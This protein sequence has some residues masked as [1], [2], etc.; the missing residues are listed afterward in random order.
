M[1][2]TRGRW[3]SG[4][5]SS[6]VNAEY[7]ERYAAAVKGFIVFVRGYGDRIDSADDL[8]YWLAY[9]A[10]HAYTT[11]KPAK[12]TLQKALAGVEHWFPEGQRLVLA[13]RCLRGWDRL[14]P[15]RPAAP[16]PRDLV[17]ACA[18]TCCLGGDLAVGVALLVAYD[19]WLRISEVAGLTPETVVD[20][21]DIA[22]PLGR[23]VSVFLPVAKT[24]RRQAVQIESAEVTALVLAWR[25]ATV[26]TGGGALFPPPDVLRRGLARALAALGADGPEWEARGLSFVWH[27]VR[28]GGAS[29]AFLADE[30]SFPRILIRGRW[31]AESSAR[32]YIQGGRQ[33]LLSLA[34][35]AH[36]ADLARRVERVGLAALLAPDLRARLRQCARA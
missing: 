2:A 15:P 19:C 16:M 34:L 22:D 30:N 17:F 36:V 21:R 26:R 13:R 6:N 8:D 14:V 11:G 32:H 4:P 12:G 29:R 28:H 31:A 35:P 3:R 9:Y 5:R 1:R 7:R 24:G 27:S 33:M 20:H 10:H 23:G 18:A 25:E